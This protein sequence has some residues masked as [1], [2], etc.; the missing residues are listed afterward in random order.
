[1]TVVSAPH[2]LGNQDRRREVALGT[3]DN[4]GH[5][6]IHRSVNRLLHATWYLTDPLVAPDVDVASRIRE[7]L[8]FLAKRHAVGN[9]VLSGA[10]THWQERLL[11]WQQADDYPKRESEAR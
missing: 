11:A 7:E 3:H 10:A 4:P 1:M 9:T 5:S 2:N 6:D 8:D